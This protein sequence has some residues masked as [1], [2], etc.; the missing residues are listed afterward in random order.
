M[1]CCFAVRSSARCIIADDSPNVNPFFEKNKKNFSRGK[2]MPGI[3][4]SL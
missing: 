3:K 4:I 1:F 2:P